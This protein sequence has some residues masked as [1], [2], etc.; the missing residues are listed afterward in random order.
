MTPH[1]WI[2]IAEKVEMMWGRSAKWARASELATQVQAV[3]HDRALKVV[4]DLVSA[5]ER[6]APSPAE[7]IGLASPDATDPATIQRL[8]EAECADQGHVYGYPALHMAEWEASCTWDDKPAGHVL[9]ICGRCATTTPMRLE[10]VTS[11]L[12]GHT[13]KAIAQTLSSELAD[14]VAP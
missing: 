11:T 1:Q 13:P 9:V 5:A 2:D 12:L 10:D 3:S 6:H 8:S 4:N 14:Q 7:I